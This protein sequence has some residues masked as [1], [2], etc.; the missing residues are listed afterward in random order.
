MFT[1]SVSLSLSLTSAFGVFSVRG[2]LAECV[3]QPLLSILHTERPD[4]YAQWIKLKVHNYP[5]QPPLGLGPVHGRRRVRQANIARSCWVWQVSGFRRF[6]E[7]YLF[8]AQIWSPD[9]SFVGRC[10]VCVIE[11]ESIYFSFSTHLHKGR[12]TKGPDRVGETFPY[13][14][15][16]IYLYPSCEEQ[17]LERGGPLKNNNNLKKKVKSWK[18]IVIPSHTQSKLMR[19]FTTTW[20]T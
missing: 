9:S 12:I 1:T 14:A 5:F 20:A 7:I 16:F 2:F 4:I 6:H 18:V 13:F 19:C 17:S 3:S 8:I 11:F 10:T 15:G